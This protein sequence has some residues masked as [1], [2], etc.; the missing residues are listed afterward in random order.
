MRCHLPIKFVGTKEASLLLRV[1]RCTVTRLARSGQLTGRLIDGPPR[2][3]STKKTLRSAKYA[4]PHPWKLAEQRRHAELSGWTKVMQIRVSAPKRARKAIAATNKSR[5][6]IWQ[7]CRADVLTFRDL[8][9]TETKQRE[10]HRLQRKSARLVALRVPR[11][12]GVTPPRVQ[13]MR[14]RCWPKSQRDA[15]ASHGPIALK[16]SNISK[17]LAWAAPLQE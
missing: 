4:S 17:L 3:A 12:Q 1:R 14:S 5:Q 11:V 16:P 2:P 9:A 15:P 13:F 6:K 7:F 10:R 8:R